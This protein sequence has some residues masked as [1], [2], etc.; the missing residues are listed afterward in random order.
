MQHEYADRLK[1]A[2]STINWSVSCD[3]PGALADIHRAGWRAVEF[4]QHSLDHL[5]TPKVLGEQ[6]EEAGLLPATLFAGV[7]PG[8]DRTQRNVLRNHV[9]FAAELG[10]DAFGL[11]GGNRLRFRPP[12]PEEYAA[13]ADLCEDL[14]ELGNELGVTVSYHPHAGCTV[15]TSGE[16]DQLMAATSRLRLCLDASHI[17]LVGEDP[18]A[19]IA[20]YWDR[21]GYIHLKDWARGKFAEMGRGTLG[22]DFGAILED[23]VR[24]DYRG[25]V[26]VEQS[27]SDDSPFESANINARFLESLGYCPGNT[28]VRS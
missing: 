28:E 17:A 15:E 21:V 20:R 2:Y 13:L 3:I 6:L 14:A 1:F 19:V 8:M 10:A 12:S 27:Q 23:L 7:E 16:I 5:G 4:F 18:L 11:V 25:W 9:R 26:V 22:I 24:R